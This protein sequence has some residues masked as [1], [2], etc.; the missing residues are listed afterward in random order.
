[1]AEIAETSGLDVTDDD[2]T[3]TTHP[4]TDEPDELDALPG[5]EG[6]R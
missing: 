4:D 5:R 1:M 2:E 3:P 6:S